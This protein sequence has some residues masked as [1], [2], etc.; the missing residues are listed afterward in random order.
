MASAIPVSYWPVAFAGV[1]I[2]VK[3]GQVIADN[4]RPRARVRVIRME[5]IPASNV[6]T[7][8][9]FTSQSDQSCYANQGFFNPVVLGY[10]YLN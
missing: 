3:P 8:F 10:A 9:I 5:K 2:M 7:A 4:Y 6:P 1:T